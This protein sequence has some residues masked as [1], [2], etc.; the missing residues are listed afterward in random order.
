MDLRSRAG[1]ADLVGLLARLILGGVLIWA[2]AAKVARP[3]LSALAVRAYKILPYDVAG[4]VG[5]ALP[6]LEILVGLLLVLGLFTRLSAALGGLLMLAFIIGISWAWAHGYSIDCGCFGGGGTIAPSQT[7]YPLE[8]LRDVG[9][10]ACAAWLVVRPRTP[11]SLD[12][13]LSG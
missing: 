13:R 1:L 10:A 3:A 11:F 5:Y 9:I 12:H 6:V 7:Q 8:I 2:G 4:Y